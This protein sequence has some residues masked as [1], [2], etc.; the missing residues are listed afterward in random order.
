VNAHRYLVPKL[1]WI[2]EGVKPPP[3]REEF[4]AA[5]PWHHEQPEQPEQPDDGGIYDLLQQALTQNRPQTTPG[6]P[7]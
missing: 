5:C 1:R 7:R 2:E 4:D 3:T 6:E